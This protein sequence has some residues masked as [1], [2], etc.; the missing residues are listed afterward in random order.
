[1]RKT[2]LM[3]LL[4]LPMLATSAQAN[5]DCTYFTF[6]L[7]GL[8]PNKSV[9]SS[10]SS[11][12]ALPLGGGNRIEFPEVHWDN[13][14][15]TGWDANFAY[16][17]Y[18]TENL[19]AEVEALYQR[20]NRKITGGFDFIETDPATDAL[21]LRIRDLPVA[22]SS[23]H[24]GV[25]SLM[26][27][28]ICDFQFDCDW[29]TFLGAGFGFAWIHSAGTSAY[30]TLNLGGAITPT[31]QTSPV[32]SGSSFA[33]QFKAGVSYAINDNLSAVLQY[34]LFA[35]GRFMAKPSRIHTNP[36]QIGDAILTIPDSTISG[37]VNSMVDIC[38]QV[39]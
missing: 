4:I 31:L 22:P 28:A 37:L 13:S 8:F 17:Y 12:G 6:G 2:L 38:I 16:G 35:T 30:N 36:G 1:M 25:Y 10:G 33:L 29:S 15:D 39:G 18:F 27:N 14:F 19:R 26:T 7:G 34:R 20:F 11:Y 23:S 3:S 9:T 5:E 32:L 24:V 21:L